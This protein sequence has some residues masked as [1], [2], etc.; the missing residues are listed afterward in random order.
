MSIFSTEKSCMLERLYGFKGDYES[1]QESYEVVH[2]ALWLPFQR[3]AYHH[4]RFKKVHFS[5]YS[6]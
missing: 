4:A 1:K 2:F 5:V 6:A 3:A